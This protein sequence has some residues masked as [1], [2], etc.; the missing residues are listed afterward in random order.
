[1]KN[2]LKTTQF[3][4][5]HNS[6]FN[7]TL[8]MSDSIFEKNEDFAYLSFFDTPLFRY[9]TQDVKEEVICDFVIGLEQA[10]GYGPSFC[11]AHCDNCCIHEIFRFE[12]DNKDHDFWTLP[13]EEFVGSSFTKQE[14]L[15]K[16]QVVRERLLQR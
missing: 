3:Q 12:R 2:N 16:I 11:V 7:T 5:E 8:N 9:L 14:A 10:H 15:A 6:N 1:M 4:L 13:E